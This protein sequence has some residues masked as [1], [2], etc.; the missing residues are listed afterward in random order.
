MGYTLRAIEEQI[1]ATLAGNGE[2]LIS[3]ISTLDGAQ[4]GELAFAEHEK[5]V[6]GPPDPRLRRDRLQGVSPHRPEK[7]PAGCEPPRRVR[8]GDVPVSI[9]NAV[10]HRHPRNRRH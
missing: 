3:G 2:E 4:P 7:P 9:L 5:Y 10:P 6:A 1:G 8:Q